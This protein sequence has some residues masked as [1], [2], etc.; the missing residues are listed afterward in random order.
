MKRDLSPDVQ[1]KLVD[2]LNKDRQELGKKTKLT[3]APL[4]RRGETELIEKI[5]FNSRN[6]MQHSRK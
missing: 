6:T 2:E 4:V 5:I 3:F 1:K